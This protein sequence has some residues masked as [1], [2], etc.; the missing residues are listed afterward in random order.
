MCVN[1]QG[2]GGAVDTSGRG[3]ASLGCLSSTDDDGGEDETD[4]RSG[5][6][7]HNFE[8]MTA[9]LENNEVRK[10]IGGVEETTLDDNP[11]NRH[12]SATGAS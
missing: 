5:D 9:A 7:S 10:Q 12:E 11:N 1:G 8:C 2:H 3:R 4:D 6:T